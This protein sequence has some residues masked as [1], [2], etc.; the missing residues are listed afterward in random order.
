MDGGEKACP[1]PLAAKAAY[2]RFGVPDAVELA[3]AG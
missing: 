3:G 1:L 2:G